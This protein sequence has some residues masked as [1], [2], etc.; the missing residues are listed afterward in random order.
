MV[1]FACMIVYCISGKLKG[2][3]QCQW[4]AKAQGAGRSGSRILFRMPR[5]LLRCFE[6]RRMA[7]FG[8]S[9]SPVE[10]GY[11]CSRTST[12]KR[13]SVCHSV[14][15]LLG[16]WRVDGADDAFETLHRTTVCFTA[17]LSKIICQHSS[18]HESWGWTN[19]EWRFTTARRFPNP[20]SMA[21]QAHLAA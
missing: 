12:L 21:T 11:E 2:R 20:V 10:V 19:V 3:A 14:R 4:E 5:G 15:I 9:D 1:R 17:Y 8:G 16:F 13:L 6:A 18:K 7:L